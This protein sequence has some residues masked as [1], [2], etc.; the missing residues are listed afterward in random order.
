MSELYFGMPWEKTN[1]T[2]KKILQ[3]I[4]VAVKECRLQDFCGSP[5]NSCHITLCPKIHGTPRQILT[6]TSN[7]NSRFENIRNQIPNRKAGVIKL[8]LSKYLTI[9]HGSGGDYLIATLK[10]QKPMDVFQ[11]GIE[12]I[13]SLYHTRMPK[14]I[15]YHVTL[16]VRKSYLSS[17]ELKAENDRLRKYGVDWE[18]TIFEASEISMDNSQLEYPTLYRL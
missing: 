10:S 15:N 16:R 14:H 18:D 1:K 2:W 17:D 5:P 11:H 3:V 9:L 13:C 6:F 7:L 4:N 8:E 12:P